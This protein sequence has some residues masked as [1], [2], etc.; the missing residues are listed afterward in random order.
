LKKLEEKDNTIK[1]ITADALVLFSGGSLGD[2]DGHWILGKSLLA[3][4]AMSE[5]NRLKVQSSDLTVSSMV[6]NVLQ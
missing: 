4:P 5:V 6:F 3:E 1:N 2:G